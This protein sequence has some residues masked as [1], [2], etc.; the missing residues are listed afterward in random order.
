MIAINLKAVWLC[1]K[2]EIPQM[3]KRVGAR[4]STRLRRSDWCDRRGLAY[5][6]AKHGVV[7]L[8]RPPRSNTHKR[9][10]GLI[11]S[12]PGFIRTAMV[13]RGLD[14]GLIGEDQ[15]I[16]IE[17][18]GRLGRPEEEIAEGSTLAISDSASFVTGHTLTIDG[19]WTAR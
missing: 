8:T 11:A 6:A 14:K 16:A 5:T 7:G 19:G 1:M 18:V 4:S 3:L 12:A 10:F 2:Y 9:I 15:M 13:E 17:P